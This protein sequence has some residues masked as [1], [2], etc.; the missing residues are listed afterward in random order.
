MA[1]VSFAVS[2]MDPSQGYANMATFRP[3]PSGNGEFL[4]PHLRSPQEHLEVIGTASSAKVLHKTDATRLKWFMDS[5]A[6][7]HFTCVRSY[8][9]DYVPDVTLVHIT[10]A[11]KHV[12]TRE[13]V[14]SI[15]VRTQ[16]NGK[17]FKLED[18]QKCLVCSSIWS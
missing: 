18:F 12:V 6:S 4:P 10:V 9:H 8:L 11:N 3:P 5:G 1:K 2:D 15:I 17:F 14:G 16:V 7:H 13:G